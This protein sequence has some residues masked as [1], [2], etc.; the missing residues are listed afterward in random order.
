MVPPAVAAGAYCDEF[1]V[2]LGVED[3]V[4]CEE[5][6]KVGLS[7]SPAIQIEFLDKPLLAGLGSGDM[8]MLVLVSLSSTLQL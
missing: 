6:A 1:I 5:S 7:Q 4:L 3:R 2:L 8:A